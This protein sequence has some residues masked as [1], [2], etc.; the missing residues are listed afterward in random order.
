L[1]LAAFSGDPQAKLP[2]P[3]LLTKEEPEREEDAV[4]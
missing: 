3:V 2:T 4:H 1:E